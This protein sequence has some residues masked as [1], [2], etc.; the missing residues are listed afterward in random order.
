MENLTVD[1]QS[2]IE[3]AAN[4]G[5]IAF[6]SKVSVKGWMGRP[7]GQP[8][9]TFVLREFANPAGRKIY[10]R[11]SDDSVGMDDEL[12]GTAIH[13][14]AS[15]P[16]RWT[17]T[18][19]SLDRNKLA[20]IPEEGL[21]KALLVA[22]MRGSHEFE[23]AKGELAGRPAWMSVSQADTGNRRMEFRVPDE[24]FKNGTMPDVTLSVL[25]L[26]QGDCRV[27][28]IYDSGDNVVRQ[29]GR[30]PGAYKLGGSFQ[31]GHGGAI[32]RYDFKLPDARFG[33][34][35]RIEATDFR[36]VA[37]KDTDFV[38]LGAFLQ[39]AAK[40]GPAN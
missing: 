32:K 12:F 10:L 20:Q 7:Q 14:K 39:A 38:I 16:A 28:L 35:L 3:E 27:S 17:A 30:E 23:V 21:Q 2:V 8:N 6:G 37:N 40:P 25:Y 33:G 26:D 9:R 4:K 19:R 15:Y 34:H 11:L 29:R 22:P 31:I 24:R 18:K 13:E 1:P 5:G 36:I